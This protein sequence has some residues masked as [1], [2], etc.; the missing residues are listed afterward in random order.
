MSYQTI[1]N[2]HPGEFAANY[3]EGCRVE[4]P[5]GAQAYAVEKIIQRHASLVRYALDNNECSG[6][7]RATARLLLLLVDL[8]AP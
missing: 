8:E 6:I 5:R 3:D 1:E 7:E 4:T 2:Q